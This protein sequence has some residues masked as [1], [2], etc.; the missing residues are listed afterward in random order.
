M[1]GVVLSDL[2]LA[3]WKTESS[4]VRQKAKVSIKNCSTSAVSVNM[5]IHS[6]N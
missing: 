1:K 4:E 2:H 3:G 5:F 6:F